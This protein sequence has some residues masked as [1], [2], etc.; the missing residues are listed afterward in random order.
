MDKKFN[1]RPRHI[2]TPETVNVRYMDEYPHITER[3]RLRRL[4]QPALSTTTIYHLPLRDRELDDLRSLMETPP[5][6]SHFSP[7]DSA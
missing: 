4:A 6:G 3:L 5:E 7:D 1:N 2:D